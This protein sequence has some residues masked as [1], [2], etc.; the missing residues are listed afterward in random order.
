M[1]CWGGHGNRA[2]RE[3]HWKL[4]S[5]KDKSWELYDLENDPGEM[6]NL[7][8][9]QQFKDVLAEHRRL[10]SEWAKISNDEEGLKYI[11]NG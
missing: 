3:G 11:K 2:V 7:A 9:D 1:L 6:R 8:H 5:A 10:L 4:V